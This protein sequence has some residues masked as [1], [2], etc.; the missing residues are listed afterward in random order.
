ML[1]QPL[2]TGLGDLARLVRAFAVQAYGPEFKPLRV[3]M[4]SWAWFFASPAVVRED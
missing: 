1:L 4:Q 3:R 2:K